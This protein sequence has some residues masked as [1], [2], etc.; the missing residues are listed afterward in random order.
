MTSVGIKLIYFFFIFLVDKFNSD[1]Q[2]LVWKFWNEEYK[3]LSCREDLF[4]K[5]FL[6]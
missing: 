3:N 5:Y 1:W 4:S 6:Q 2:N